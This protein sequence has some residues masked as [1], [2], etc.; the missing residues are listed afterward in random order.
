M[1]RLR[2]A[3]VGAGGF[4]GGHLNVLRNHPRV[5]LKVVCDASQD[6]LAPLKEQGIATSGDF[7]ETLSREDLDA[8]II[9][10]PHYLYP[11]AVCMA[12]EN[13]IHVL[14]EK[15]FAKDLSDARIMMD[16]AVKAGR[17]LMVAGQGKYSPGFQRAGEL[18][19]S[20]MLGDIFLSRGV[21]T[22]RW[23]GAFNDGWRWRGVRE[24]SGGVAVID[25]GWHMLD[26]LH[27]L[28]GMPEKVYCSLGQGNALP[29]EYDVDDRACLVFDYPD[30][31][32]GN[33]IC[34]FICQPSSRQV[35]LHGTQATLDVTATRVAIH[36]GETENSEVVTFAGD[37]AGLAPQF[38]RFLG[39]ID[40]GAEP[41]AGAVEAFNIQRIIDAAY[42]SAREG[43][44]VE[45]A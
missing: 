6:V 23:G 8:A 5:D 21:I 25:S 17:V 39:L 7:R 36:S 9:V 44:P 2:F 13:G 41:S 18:V 12:L 37:A 15:P 20:G 28:R 11:D 38:E 22:Y 32:L 43:V 24:K 16:C 14:K 40:S 35:I 3:L 30:G 26:I 33:V 4:G 29:G 27:W 31:G 45:P 34:C 1:D 42:R 10:L 19:R